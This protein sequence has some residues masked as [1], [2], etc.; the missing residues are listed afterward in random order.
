MIKRAFLSRLVMIEISAL[1]PPGTF[2]QQTSSSASE[3]EL[4]ALVRRE[5]GPAFS[6]DLVRAFCADHG[7]EVPDMGL[8]SGQA[9]LDDEG[10]VT[11]LLPLYKDDAALLRMLEE[12]GLPETETDSVHDYFKNR[13]GKYGE[14]LFQLTSRSFCA[15]FRIQV[16]LFLI[17]F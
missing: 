8:T 5:N 3:T 4:L 14:M 7:I 13:K 15:L 12:L 10:R 6:Y 16:L 17:I 11:S 9:M 1:P 2:P